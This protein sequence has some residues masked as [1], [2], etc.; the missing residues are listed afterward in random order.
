MTNELDKLLGVFSEIMEERER[1]RVLM[2]DDHPVEL[3]PCLAGKE[4]LSKGCYSNV[5]EADKPH[6]VYKLTCDLAYVDFMLTNDG[7]PGLP[8][9][10]S[11]MGLKNHPGHKP[12]A[13]LEIQRLT[14]LDKWKHE[15][16][17]A[18]SEAVHSMLRYRVLKSEAEDGQ[19]GHVRALREVGKSG[20]FS[21]SVSSALLAMSRF[22]ANTR[23]RLVLDLRNPDNFMTDGERLILTDPF[24][25]FN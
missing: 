13:L 11:Y 17:K 25:L 22:M 8:K 16:M 7:V 15:V 24:D 9:L 4:L 1:E 23:H 21:H 2:V 10:Y 6:T 18:E 3:F 19:D 5:Y 12:L 14:H 20:L